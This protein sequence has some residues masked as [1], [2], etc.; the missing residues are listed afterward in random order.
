MYLN[1]LEYFFHYSVVCLTLHDLYFFSLLSDQDK[2]HDH[3]Y[4]AYN[5]IPFWWHVWHEDDVS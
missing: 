5:F 2:I 3:P 1:R 4:P